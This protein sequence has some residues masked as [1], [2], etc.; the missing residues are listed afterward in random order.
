MEEEELE[1]C[2]PLH[3]V[4]D[5]SDLV[6]DRVGSGLGAVRGDFVTDLC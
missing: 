4:A 6:A 3:L 2:L 5:A 1:P